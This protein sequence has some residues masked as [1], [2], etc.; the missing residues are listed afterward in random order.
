MCGIF[1]RDTIT[2]APL[3]RM[4]IYSHAADSN[5]YC[6]VVSSVNIPHIG[7]RILASFVTCFF[8]SYKQEFCCCDDNRTVPLS[9][10]RGVEGIDRLA[11]LG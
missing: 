8:F 7:R 1:T 9:E 6:I 11:A 2:I 10:S 3:I 5:T 4:L